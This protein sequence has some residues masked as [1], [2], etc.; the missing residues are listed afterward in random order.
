VDE[1]AGFTNLVHFCLSGDV[2]V[3]QARL[4]RLRA[5]HLKALLHT[6]FLFQDIP[7]ATARN[8]SHR[9]ILDPQFR[10]IWRLLLQSHRALLK[11][12]VV[13]AIY[14]VDEPA[15]NGL[16]NADL[17]T[18]CQLIKDSLPD[19][20]LMLVEAYPAVE[21]VSIPTVV[22]WVG[23]DHFATR[24]P[25]TN[26]EWQREWAAIK[27]RRSTSRQ[28]LVL[29][30][31]ASLGPEHVAA[32]LR[33]SELVDIARE[34]VELA[35]RE[36]E[37]VALIGYAWPGGIGGAG[38]KGARSLPRDYRDYVTTIGRSIVSGR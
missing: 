18:V 31:D 27:A 32:G 9:T 19:L 12:D 29:A 30:F 28:K 23:F 33:E 5:R 15:W 1:V 7:D 37:V 4:E 10:E 8:G 26:N 16:P 25:L 11:S 34:Y 21:L 6:Q 24:H 36:P 35:R 38:V 14:V 13:A 17:A 20:P 3:D 2:A 22:D